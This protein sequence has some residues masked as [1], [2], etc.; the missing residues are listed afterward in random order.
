V[1]VW[2]GELLGPGGFNPTT[3]HNVQFISVGLF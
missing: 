2:S 1:H 3:K